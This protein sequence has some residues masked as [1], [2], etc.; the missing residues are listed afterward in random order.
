[1]R[2]SKNGIRHLGLLLVGMLC[3]SSCQREV[4]E[5]YT[6]TFDEDLFISGGWSSVGITSS[7][8]NTVGWSD[9]K[10]YGN[11]AYSDKGGREANEEEAMVDF[12]YKMAVFDQRLPLLYEEYRL[13]EVDSAVGT[14]TLRLSCKSG[15]ERVVREE[16]RQVRY[17]SMADTA[18][19]R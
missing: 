16:S 17:V 13:A 1:M 4:T 12:D 18:G 7:F 3:F 11:E 2:N 6:F 8:L 10:K 9:V 5:V 19:M 15:E 14:V